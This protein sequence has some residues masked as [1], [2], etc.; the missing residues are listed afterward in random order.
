MVDAGR[1]DRRSRSAVGVAGDAGARRAAPGALDLAVRPRRSLRDGSCA[2]TA[3]VELGAPVGRGRAVPVTPA[4]GASTCP[5][6]GAALAD[7]WSATAWPAVEERLREAVAH[8]DPLADE[9]SRHLVERRRQAGAPDAHPARRAPGRRRPRP[10]C[11]DAAVVVELT[12]LATLY[13]DDVMDSAPL[14]R[15]A[16]AAHEVWGNSVAILTGDLL[17]AR[18]STRRGRARRRG[19]A[20]PGGD[21]RAA[22]PRAAARDASARG[23]ARTRS[24]HYL[25]VLADKTGSLIA[26]A[27]P[28]SARCSP[29]A[30]AEVVDV[31]V[32]LRREGRRRVPARRR[33]HRPGRRR[34]RSP[35]RRPAPTCA[36]ACRRC[37][38]CWRAGPRPPA[39]P[40]AA[41][42]VALLDGDL[43][44]D[45]VLADAVAGCAST[46]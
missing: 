29:A 46:R 45:A 14:R 36:R 11:V 38:C 3:G 25:Q 26:T 18:A 37:R 33:R 16:P 43:S 42:V 44:D 6:G 21:V 8:A 7:R 20:H 24:Q 39:T 35:A 34:R 17:F 9:A 30:R 40:A 28:A 41:E 5:I 23:R 22:V 19:G 15:G 13:H 12:H 27:G 1:A 32:G 2:V 31:L 4:R 10:R